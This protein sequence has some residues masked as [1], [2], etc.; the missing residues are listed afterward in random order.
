MAEAS[1]QW[2][3]YIAWYHDF[4]EAEINTEE[5]AVKHYE[6][7]GRKEGRSPNPCLP[8][9]P[10]Q[11]LQKIMNSGKGTY[12]IITHKRGGGSTKYLND[13]ISFMRSRGY[14]FVFMRGKDEMVDIEI[15][16]CIYA[17][18]LVT[19]YD[20]IIDFMSPLHLKGVHVNHVIDFPEQISQLLGDLNLPYI[21]TIH[22][23]FFISGNFED[24]RPTAS[25]EQLR[26]YRSI[27]LFADEVFVPS[28]SVEKIYKENYPDAKFTVVP[29]EILQFK[30]IPF[31]RES[32][33]IL[34]IGI[35]GF[36][37]YIKG[38]N[39]IIEC[40][41]DSQ[42]KKLNHMY[43]IYGSHE[44]VAALPSN[45]VCHGEYKNYDHLCDMLKE[46][47][48]DIFLVPGI[49]HE[50]YCYVL[51]DL[52]RQHLPICLAK[53]PIFEERCKDMKGIIFYPP[54]SNATIINTSLASIRRKETLSTLTKLTRATL[55]S[56]VNPRYVSYYEK[57]KTNVR[58]V[59]EVQSSRTISS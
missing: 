36:I 21:V 23:W 43:H 38:A 7:H 34:N 42:K 55:I 3:K 45:V 2:E 40:A 51:T 18:N 48:I 41:L 26:Y 32:N 58:S 8:I 19:E 22:D 31:S 59:R 10:P 25:N 44:S 49:W 27:L 11:H 30:Q 29:H 24:N 16:G 47:P 46:T 53:Y 54:D 57:M 9:I 5:K 6:E 15:E 39:V 33:V 1:L 28:E 4:E 52:L 37:S 17:L 12:L 35:L 20:H 13:L 14:N 56:P 50:T